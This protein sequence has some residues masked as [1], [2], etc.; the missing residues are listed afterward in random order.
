M[1]LLAPYVSVLH[2]SLNRIADFLFFPIL[3]RAATEMYIL[4]A[5]VF[6]C[7]LFLQKSNKIFIL[8]E[9]LNILLANEEPQEETLIFLCRLSTIKGQQN[10]FNGNYFTNIC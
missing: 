2:A 4:S 10:F 9:F 7:F 3:F 1:P 6:V 5:L 8:R